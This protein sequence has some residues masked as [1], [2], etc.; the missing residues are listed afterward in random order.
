MRICRILGLVGSAWLLVWITIQ[1][2]GDFPRNADEW[3][4]VAPFALLVF[5]F[6]PANTDSLIGLWIEAKKA[7]LRKQINYQKNL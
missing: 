4:L 7:E 5:N 2:E 6:F 3:F 1:L